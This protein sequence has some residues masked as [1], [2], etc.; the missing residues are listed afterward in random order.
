VQGQG[1]AWHIGHCNNSSVEGTWCWT[2]FTKEAR[3]SGWCS[4]EW[5]DKVVVWRGSKV[6]P[7]ATHL[8]KITCTPYMELWKKCKAEY[9]Y[10]WSE[11]MGGHPCKNLMVCNF[12]PITL[13]CTNLKIWNIDKRM[14]PTCSNLGKRPHEM[15]LGN[16]NTK[17]LN[18]VRCA[19]GDDFEK[20]TVECK[21]CKEP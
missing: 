11:K 3:K 18:F 16:M 6:V 19:Y 17:L 8:E 20:G 2:C 5:N 9:P 7:M 15:K 13:V 14:W 21:T 10:A 12:A 4:L 1:C